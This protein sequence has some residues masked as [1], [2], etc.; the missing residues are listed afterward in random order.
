MA[1]TYIDPPTFQRL[2]KLSD[3]FIRASR[4]CYDYLKKQLV[5]KYMPGIPHE[6]VGGEFFYA[7][8][9]VIERLPGHGFGSVA[10][11]GASTFT[12]PGVR[13]KEG[14][15]G[16]IGPQPGRAQMLGHRWLLRLVSP[17]V[18]ACSLSLVALCRWDTR[19]AF[20]S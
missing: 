20:R 17:Y 8:R 19:R 7:I 18:I 16:L 9:Q 15:Q 10:H 1:I 5:I 13:S 12:V 2:S 6:L 3:G 14:D 11:L 4:L